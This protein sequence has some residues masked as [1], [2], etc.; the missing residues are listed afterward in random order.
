[1][2]ATTGVVSAFLEALLAAGKSP[3][4]RR[5]Y[6]ADVREFLA[7]AGQGP[8]PSGSGLARVDRGVIRAYAGEL[9]RVG[10]AAASTSRKLAAVRAFFRFC[11]VAGDLPVSPA[12]RV[13]GPKARRRLPRVLRADE[14]VAVIEGPTAAA[15]GGGGPAPGSGQAAAALEVQSEAAGDGGPAPGSDPAT[16]ALG[17]ETRG[18]PAHLR[19]RDRAMLEVLYGAGVRVAE[20]CGLDVRDLDLDLGQATVTGKGRKTRIVPLGEYAALALGE[21]LRE[22]R[23]RLGAGASGAVFLNSR[24]KRLS[25]RSVRL[26]VAAAARLAGLPGNVHPHTFRHTFATH[27]LDGGADLR[28]VQEMLGHARLSTTQ[29]YTHLTLQRLR[30]AYDKAHPRA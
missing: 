20:L 22:G 30:A 4:T 11:V 21:Y 15:A 26:D 29:V 6:A 25:Q 14:A 18:R 13:R 28:A 9:Q 7:W 27:L 10:L 2:S 16:A 5:A 17:R 23:P 1:V 24:G 12:E 19:L 8:D 3:H